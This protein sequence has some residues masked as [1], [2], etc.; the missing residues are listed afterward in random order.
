[1]MLQ[2]AHRR[3]ESF[4][5][6]VGVLVSAAATV[7]CFDDPLVVP[8]DKNGGVGLNEV[9]KSVGEKL[10]PNCFC[11]PDVMAI[12]VL[13]V[14]YSPGTPVPLDADPNADGGAGIQVGV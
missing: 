14:L 8:M 3:Y 9:E 13:P 11:P 5:D 1:M 6:E 4:E 2:F 10:E 7:P 12:C